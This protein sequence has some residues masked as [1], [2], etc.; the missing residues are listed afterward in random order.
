MN[1]RYYFFFILIVVFFF[2]FNL[3]ASEKIAFID[4]NVVFNQSNF[5][6][7]YNKDLNDKI[8]S[9]NKKIKDYQNLINAEKIEI[10]KKKNVISNDD[11]KTLLKSLDN[12]I[13]N[14]NEI[15]NNEQNDIA[16]FKATKQKIF[17]DSLL[18]ILETYSI[19]QSIDI[20][21]KKENLLIAKKNLDITNELVILINKINIKDN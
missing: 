4:L 16:K 9:H 20:I 6:Q 15:V 18:P 21:L 5:G 11:Y 14:F 10:E 1:K 13:I 8:T 19:D 2:K 3:F 17:L 12:K 7:A